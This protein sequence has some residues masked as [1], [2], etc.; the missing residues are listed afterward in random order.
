MNLSV[1]VRVSS[2]GGAPGT[3]VLAF[4]KGP[5]SVNR[6]RLNKRRDHILADEKFSVYT[7]GIRVSLLTKVF[8]V[9]Y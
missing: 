4:S 3:S 7:P 9:V 5:S 2:S 8:S 1:R 6:E